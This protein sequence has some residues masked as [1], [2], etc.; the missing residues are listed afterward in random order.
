MKKIIRLLLGLVLLLSL[1]S[2]AVAASPETYAD[3]KPEHWAYGEITVCTENGIFKGYPDGSFR[4]E[5]TMTRADAEAA[6][7]RQFESANLTGI[8]ND[9]EMGESITREE[10]AYLIS[11]ANGYE[12]TDAFELEK[13]SDKAEVSENYKA[14]L[15]AAVSAGIVF[16]HSDKTLRPNEA[17]TRSEFAVML[18][19]AVYGEEILAERRA[20]AIEYMN[21]S[22]TLLWTPTEDITLVM[23]SNVT[24]EEADDNTA[25]VYRAGRIYHGVPYSYAGGTANGFLDYAVEVDENG[26]YRVD[27]LTWENI[28]GENGVGRVGNDCSSTLLQAWGQLGETFTATTT[29]Y[30]TEKHGCIPV[31]DYKTAYENYGDDTG[32]IIEEN[33]EQAIFRAYSLMKPADAVV[34]RKSGSGHCIMVTDVETVYLSDGTIDGTNSKVTVLEQT[35]SS[36]KKER[37]YFD[38]KLG[39][40]VYKVGI[41]AT[42]SFASLLRNKYVPITCK[43]LRDPSLIAEPVV[44]DTE[45][46]FNKGTVL[47]GTL[48]CNW[49]MDSIT[50]DIADE[51]G[52]NVQSATAYVS[53]KTGQYMSFDMQEFVTAKPVLVRGSVDMES[54]ETGKYSCEVTVRLVTGQKITVR[55]FEFEV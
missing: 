13:F 21:N 3:L 30:L 53:R 23:K 18:Y 8:W 26:V 4:P 12:N 7:T 20:K 33:G 9:G 47:K 49:M 34:R 46:V 38:E 45:T 50:L 54:L 29:G 17:L 11:K 42:Y 15:S 48:A 36:F 43:A 24:P 32:N 6:V 19:R 40:D 22:T 5:E 25:F 28:S 10:A 14:E 41:G 44:T 31:G 35:A 16:G 55:D 1:Y 51:R 37:T 52:N 27:G 2:V 39:C